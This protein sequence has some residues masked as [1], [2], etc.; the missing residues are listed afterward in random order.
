M[1]MSADHLAGDNDWTP[2]SKRLGPIGSEIARD[3]CASPDARWRRLITDPISGEL[4]AMDTRVPLIGYRGT[5]AKRSSAGRLVPVPRGVDS[6]AEF[7][8]CDHIVPRAEVNLSANLA[9]LCR[10][11]HR[12]NVLSTWKVGESTFSRRG[13]NW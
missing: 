3:L 9:G 5:C 7:F 6:R 10:R 1:W 2:E 13:M 4:V 11:H 8:D 12:T